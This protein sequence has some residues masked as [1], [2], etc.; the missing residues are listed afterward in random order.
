MEE[1]TISSIPLIL[2]EVGELV[3]KKRKDY[4]DLTFKTAS[5]I[6][7]I[8]QHQV[9][10]SIYGIKLTRLSNLLLSVKK[11]PNYESIEDTLK[12]LIGYLAL[13]IE[14]LRNEETPNE[15]N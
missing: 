14:I 7:G 11:S 9:F 5:E 13:H 3:D 8:S 15:F 2:K 12:D 4:S 6:A 1:P 10:L